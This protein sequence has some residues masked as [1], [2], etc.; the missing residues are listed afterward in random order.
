MTPVHHFMINI[1]MSSF[2]EFDKQIKTL[3]MFGAHNIL[4]ITKLKTTAEYKNHT[5]DEARKITV[6]INTSLIELLEQLRQLEIG[7]RLTHVNNITKLITDFYLESIPQIKYVD[8]PPI[9]SV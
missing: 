5:S 1:Y 2:S 8:D 4:K 3:N 9:Y 7:D 6:P